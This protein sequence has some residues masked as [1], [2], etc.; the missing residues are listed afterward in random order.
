M[1]EQL[2]ENDFTH[3]VD[4]AIRKQEST[5]AQSSDWPDFKER[6]GRVKGLKEAKEIFDNLVNHLRDYD[7]DDD[8]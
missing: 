1:S 7:E 4:M 8:D 6:V 3:A 2:V 5:L